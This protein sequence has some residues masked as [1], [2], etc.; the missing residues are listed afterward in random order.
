MPAIRIRKIECQNCHY[1]WVS[2]ALGEIV[3]CPM[4][5]HKINTNKQTIEEIFNSGVN[6]EKGNNE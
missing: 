5:Y 1:I 3:T 2:K 6:E 4:C